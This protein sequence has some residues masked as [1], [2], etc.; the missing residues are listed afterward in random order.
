MHWF[1]NLLVLLGLGLMATA[2]GA[3]NLVA[4]PSFEQDSAGKGVPDRWR[5]EGDSRLVTQTLT[6]D[7]G[8]DGKHCAKLACTKFRAG[9]PAAHAMLCQLG[10]PVERGK[11]YRVT[12]WARAENITADIVSLALSDTS[13]WANCG[14][15]SAFVTTPQWQKY[16]FLFQATRDCPKTS[17]LQIWFG[18]T[19]TLWVDDIVF[20][21]A[22]RELVRPGHII[23]AGKRVNLLPNASFECGTDGWGSAQWDR[24][25][26]WGG[27][28]NR[29]FGELD[30]KEAFDG[31]AS[32]RID[33]TPENQ[34]VCFF[35][36]Y[37]LHRAPIQAPLAANIGWIEVEPGKPHVLSVYMKARE[38]RTPARL[39]VREFHG[40]TFETAVHVSAEWQRYS[41][42][43]TPTAKWCYVLAGPDLRATSENP[44]P[45][46]SAR[47]WLDALQLQQ[48][49]TPTAFVSRDPVEFGITAYQ[50][51]SETGT[52]LHRKTEEAA[53]VF[54]AD[55]R[56]GFVV[57]LHGSTAG[58]GAVE[59]DLRVSDFFD[60]EVWRH[61]ETLKSF[62]PRGELLLIHADNRE[63]PWQGFFRLHATLTADHVK[64]EKTM[65]LAKIPVTTAGESRFGVNH[66]YPWPHLLDLSHK[67]G[68]LWVRDW[69]LKWQDVEPEPG[70]FTFEEPDR[71]IDR[72]RKADLR[73]LG[74]VPFPSSNWSSSAPES[75][76][77]TA[78]YPGNRARVAYAPRDEAEFENFVEQSVKHY[79][80]RIRWWQVFNEPLYTDYSLPRARGYNAAD[81]ARWTKAFAKAARRADPQCRV[82]AG[83][84]GI[85]D[86][87]IMDDFERFFAAG[88]LAAVDAIDIHHYPQLRPPEFIEGL[89]EKLN[90]LMDK[91]GGRKPIWMTEYGYY[92]ED[93]PWEVP[94][95][96]RGFDQPL[97]SERVQAEYAVRWATI[98]VAGGVDKIFYHA[99]TCGGIND[100]SLEGVFFD[101][102][103]APRKVYAAQAVLA[104]VLTPT[105]R[106]VKRLSLGEGVRAYLF[107]DGTRLWAVVWAQ[108]DAKP[109]PIRLTD[110]GLDLFDIMCRKQLARDF[111]P[112]GT[113]VYVR[114]D[115]LSDEAFA[116]GLH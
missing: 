89:L 98:L 9:N 110:K 26:H 19:G 37:E 79:Q 80:G 17:R 87:Q 8:C 27:P 92:A 56:I 58:K 65:R 112:D 90:A 69:S 29:L 4:N 53:N 78:S 64:S 22:G 91:H 32:L 30:Y 100:G 66:A 83:I 94:L 12:L 114:G 102:G 2:R 62:D 63:R 85:N 48:A 72:A 67:A 116:A 33:L 21:E 105:C 20:E 18:S 115:D 74:L 60:H 71:Q 39:A 13:V 77:V 31:Q 108:P 23:P 14:L 55:E 35:D 73:V 109:R 54:A 43:F 28:M 81:Y 111:T 52:E 16:E 97:P 45:P 113:P 10:V 11:H 6:L 49:R 82:L 42:G 106:L 5:A 25:T 3:E 50:V 95:L 41:L 46:K 104:R 61:R 68:L 7:Q 107:R 44:N 96:A 86:G 24:T 103:G 36:Y 76:K 57:H 99:G 47:L 34:P 40:R 84:G 59:L 70:R 93:Q 51:P 1:G 101:Y 75:V 38:A 15:E 88:G